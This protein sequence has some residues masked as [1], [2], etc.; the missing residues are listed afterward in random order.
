[1][2]GALAEVPGGLQRVRVRRV[3]RGGLD[4]MFFFRF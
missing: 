2:T 4:L 1:V 3:E